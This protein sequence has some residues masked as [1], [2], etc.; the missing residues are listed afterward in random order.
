MKIN[1]KVMVSGNPEIL[2]VDAE[3]WDCKTNSLQVWLS[4]KLASSKSCGH[5]Q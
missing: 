3:M 1:C 5:M 2:P 4:G